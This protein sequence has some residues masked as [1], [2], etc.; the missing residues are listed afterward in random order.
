MVTEKAKVLEP[1]S[2]QVV[3]K[4]KGVKEKNVCCVEKVISAYDTIL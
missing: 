4:G 2:G 3:Q 1:S